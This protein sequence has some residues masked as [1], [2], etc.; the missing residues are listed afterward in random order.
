M[1]PGHGAKVPRRAQEGGKVQ[2]DRTRGTLLQVT[3]YSSDGW[4]LKGKG[5]TDQEGTSGRQRSDLKAGGSITSQIL[6]ESETFG[7][8]LLSAHYRRV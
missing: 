7:T 6:L 8:F 2:G 5:G 1:R 3:G 4:R